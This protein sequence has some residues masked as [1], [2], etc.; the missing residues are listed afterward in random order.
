MFFYSFIIFIYYYSIRN[1]RNTAI[2][3]TKSSC[4]TVTDSHKPSV[5]TLFSSVTS[6]Q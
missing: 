4:Y 2:H 6:L 3:K 5:S 1:I